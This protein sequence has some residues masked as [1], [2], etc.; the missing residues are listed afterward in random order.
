MVFLSTL[1][2]PTCQV[3]RGQLEVAPLVSKRE[4]NINQPT[5]P[6]GA[7]GRRRAGVGYR[8]NN[9]P[10]WIGQRGPAG[11]KWAGRLGSE[12]T[13]WAGAFGPRE[14]RVGGAFGPRED[15]VGGA[16]GLAEDRVGGLFRHR[17]STQPPSDLVELCYL[18]RS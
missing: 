10:E 9:R 3:C 15:R 7:W 12:R 17:G 18:G 13:G 1:T 2:A 5:V 8:K 11:T 14:D 16:F 4:D 6:G